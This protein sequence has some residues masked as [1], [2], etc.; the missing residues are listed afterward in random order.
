MKRKNNLDESRKF[1]GK[2]LVESVGV[3]RKDW[4]QILRYQIPQVSHD[5]DSSFSQP[6]YELVEIQLVCVFVWL[7]K[8]T[9]RGFRCRVEI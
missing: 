7:G 5:L 8:D 4:E 9:V 3:E 2:S 1:K 6:L